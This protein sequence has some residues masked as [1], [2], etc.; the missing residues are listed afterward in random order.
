MGFF[1]CRK[2]TE[3]EK[4]SSLKKR[5]KHKGDRKERWQN[6]PLKLSL[7]FCLKSKHSTLK[8]GCNKIVT[9]L[10]VV[11]LLC[12]FVCSHSS[13][14]IL[15]LNLEICLSVVLKGQGVAIKCSKMKQS[16]EPQF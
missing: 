2:R 5:A 6:K 14:D 11:N 9:T 1:L 4:S 8:K 16:D 15:S 13:R 10:E 3:I 12:N 7:K